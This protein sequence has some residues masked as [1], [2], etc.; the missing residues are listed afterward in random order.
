[1][2]ALLDKIR[3]YAWG[4]GQVSRLGRPELSLGFLGGIGDDLLCTVPI[5]EWLARGARRIWFFT[6]HPA[7][8]SYD[9]RVRLL[10]EDPRCLRLAWR[11]GQPMRAVSYSTYDPTTDRD[12][13]VR[14]HII[15]DM[16]RRAG[17][18]GRVRLLP[19]VAL[20]AEEKK[21]AKEWSGCA[22]IQTSSLTAS[23]PMQNKQWP[24]D[25]FQ[26]VA[27]HLA[28]LGVRVVQVG[29]QSD[30]PLTG[31]ID[32]RGRTSLRATAAVLANARL[33]VGLT[34][35]LM[36]LARA[37]DCPAVIVYGG[38]EPP[39]LTGYPCNVNVTNRP[40]CAPCWQ[41]SRCDFGHVCMEAITARHVID[42]ISLLL[43]RP[44]GPLL[45]DEADL[46]AL[47]PSP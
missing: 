40:P 31:V 17:L 30:P 14:E 26:T 12:T 35:F 21:R 16:C 36:H 23:V 2:S 20:G 19:R 34:G 3:L 41:R 46:P 29:S 45:V 10:P 18:T 22:A 47:S 7:L 32:L 33:F 5:D 11:L 13:A 28:K 24:A 43:A 44:R 4:V 39:E 38:R 6:R 27:D 1:V 25:R 9:D 37:V 8:Y 15:T 42:G